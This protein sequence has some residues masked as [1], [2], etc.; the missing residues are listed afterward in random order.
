MTG[1]PISV[2][3]QIINIRAYLRFSER[4]DASIFFIFSV[5][6]AFCNNMNLSQIKKGE[7]AVVIR[8]DADQNIR[9]RL[10]MLNVFPSAEVKVVRYSLFRSSILL[11]VGGIRLGI[12]RELAEHIG[13]LRRE[14]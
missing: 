6:L 14:L 1:R 8:V 11:E 2:P 9:E 3:E 7:S 13:V 4:Q 10:R 5:L 12:R